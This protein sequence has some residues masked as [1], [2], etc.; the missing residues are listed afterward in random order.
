MAKRWLIPFAIVLSVL[1]TF[2]Y[3]ASAA[4]VTA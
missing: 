2:T 4:G 1:F 3:S